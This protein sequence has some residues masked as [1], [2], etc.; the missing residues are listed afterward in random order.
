MFIF[1]YT[2]VEL[3]VVE[4][5]LYGENECILGNISSPLFVALIFNFI[6]YKCYRKPWSI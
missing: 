2:Q 4:N 5:A 6:V 1:N 3:G